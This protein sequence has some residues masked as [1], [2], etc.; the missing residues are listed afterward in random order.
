MCPRGDE[1]QLYRVDPNDPTVERKDQQC[2]H[3]TMHS[4][5]TFCADE[6]PCKHHTD[7]TCMPLRLDPEQVGRKQ[8]H[9]APRVQG[10]G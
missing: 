6:T 8:A 1:D 9:P 2:R 10:C 7:G 3:D 5:T 4:K